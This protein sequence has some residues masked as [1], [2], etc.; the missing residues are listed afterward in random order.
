MNGT[1]LRLK[2]WTDMRRQNFEPDCF[3]NLIDDKY[4][5]YLVLALF[6]S[7]FAKPQPDWP[8]NTVLTGFVFYDGS[9]GEAELIPELKQFL[10]AG[11]P[12]IVFTLGS[13]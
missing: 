6:S 8:A 12:P 4:S 11:E 7:I 5:P 13:A 2:P 10:D 1:L 3:N 9:N